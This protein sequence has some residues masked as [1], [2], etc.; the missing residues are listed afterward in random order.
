MTT[1]LLGFD[2]S[3]TARPNWTEATYARP[4]L[5][6]IATSLAWPTSGTN[7]TRSGF[8]ITAEADEAAH[9]SAS[10]RLIAIRTFVIHMLSSNPYSRLDLLKHGSRLP[11]SGVARLPV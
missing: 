8:G 11:A 10:V 4:V 1:G 7:P 9:N 5:G 2:T 6:S 3:T